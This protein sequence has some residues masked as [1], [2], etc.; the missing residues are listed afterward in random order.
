MTEIL[1]EIPRWGFMW[2]LAAAIYAACKGLS[3]WPLRS[4]GSAARSAGYLLL[5]PGMDARAFLDAAARPERPPAA[6]W[7]FAAGKTM[8]GAALVWIVAP[9]AAAPLLKGWIGLVGM[10]FILHFGTF[11]LL[12]L[13]WRSAG[14]KAEP[15]MRAPIL[16]T[17]LGDFWGRRW[18]LG[19]R[20]LA[21]DLL[22]KPLAPR[23]GAAA[24]GFAVFL[25][26]GLVH[27]LVISVPAGGGYGLPTGYFALQGLGVSIERSRSGREFGLG[28]GIRGWI[29]VA[30]FTAGPAIALFH[31]AFIREVWL[32]FMTAIGIK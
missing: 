14:V 23:F 29:F 1:A 3:W 24:A 22:F 17:S 8:A 16:A 27:D 10:I 32:P 25:A 12:S 28:W 4:R 30:L 19:F 18:N 13:G 5:W 11:H 15:I 31:P 6:E 26:S 2:A 20:D 7:L 21:H 9:L